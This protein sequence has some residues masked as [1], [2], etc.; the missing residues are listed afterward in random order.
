[1]K[2][3][4]GRISSIFCDLKIQSVLTPFPKKFVCLLSNARSELNIEL[5]KKYIFIPISF[6]QLADFLTMKNGIC[7]RICQNR[8]KF[9]HT[10]TLCGQNAELFNVPAGGRPTYQKCTLKGAAAHSSSCVMNH[11]QFCYSYQVRHWSMGLGVR[12]HYPLVKAQ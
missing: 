1:M 2:E 3:F 12:I 4:G 6:I 5:K 10:H 11:S 9:T 7:I 8:V